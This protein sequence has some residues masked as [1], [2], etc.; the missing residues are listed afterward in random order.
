MKTWTS[1]SRRLM[2]MGMACWTG[3]EVL[4]SLALWTRLMKMAEPEEPASG[5]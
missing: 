5:F 4:A 3:D 2:R 1:S